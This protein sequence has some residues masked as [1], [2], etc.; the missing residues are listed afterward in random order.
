M[1]FGQIQVCDHI[2]VIGLSVTVRG[3]S[4]SNHFPG[5]KPIIGIH[6]KYHYI[7]LYYITLHYIILHYITLN[8]NTYITFHYFTLLILQSNT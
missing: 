6:P 5:H 4:V 8:Y 2:S 7:A 3:E 1:V